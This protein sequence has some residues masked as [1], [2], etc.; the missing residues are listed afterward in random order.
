M[1]NKLFV[2]PEGYQVEQSEHN[3]RVT[4]SERNRFGILGI[5]FAGGLFTILG[6]AMVAGKTDNPNS[7]QV[8]GGVMSLLV[9][10]PIIYL[11]LVQLVNRYRIEVTSSILSIHS[12]PLPAFINKT[13]DSTQIE[14]LCVKEAKDREGP[15][16][17]QLH[18]VLKDGSTSK[19]IGG[20]EYSHCAQFLK[21]QIQHWL[22]IH[23]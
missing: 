20:L 21:Q 16:T 23:D 2:A 15:T 19:L 3:L 12:S 1:T 8:V 7:I 13:F 11:G 5:F 18:I 4:F 9:G 17:Y 22:G 14:R 10:I 6:G